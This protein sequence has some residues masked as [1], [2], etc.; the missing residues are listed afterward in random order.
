MDEKSSP[1]K[2]YR[3]NPAELTSTR[4]TPIDDAPLETTT[5]PGASAGAGAALAAGRLWRATKANPAPITVVHF[6][7]RQ[8]GVTSALA[9]LAAL[10]AIPL[11]VR[12]L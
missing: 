2:S 12:M 1:V 11:A 8:P 4:P 3:E 6:V 7:H 5:D 10:R 9:R